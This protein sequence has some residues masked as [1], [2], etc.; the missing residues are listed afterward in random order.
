MRTLV[1]KSRFA[2]SNPLPGTP[3]LPTY[4]P[5]LMAS[6]D[7]TSM[8][9]SGT[10]LTKWRNKQGAWGAQADLV[11]GNS[12]FP[13]TVENGAAVFQGG[14]SETYMDSSA[15]A[16]PMQVGKAT[17]LARIRFGSQADLLNCTVF[18]SKT[19]DPKVF[20][21]RTAPGTFEAGAGTPSKMFTTDVVAKEVWVDVAFV[22]D[23]A[24]SKIYLGDKVTI[25]DP[26]LNG[27][28]TDMPNLRLGANIS[29]A[30]RLNGRIS[31][32]Q[33]YNRAI[34]ADELKEIRASL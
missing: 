28:S 22:L 8:D 2:L 4:D 27:A 12:Q 9:V 1:L 16:Q 11:T 30:N 33:V 31:H 26:F 10:T 7:A 17:F 14:S 34:G 23:G 29:G 21:R 32:F 24:N 5:S 18:A 13:I 15:F 3:V 25:G 19:T 6:Y 20:I